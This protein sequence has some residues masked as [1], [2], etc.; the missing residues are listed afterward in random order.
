[1]TYPAGAQ[2]ST[3]LTTYTESS[4][5]TSS[6]TYT[7]GTTQFISTITPT[8]YDGALLLSGWRRSGCSATFPF[9]AKPGDEITINF[10]SDTPIDFHLVWSIFPGVDGTLYC[11]LGG[12]AS[13]LSDADY[14]TSYS[15]KWSPPIDHYKVTGNTQFYIVLA[16]RQ[17][18]P[19]SV[20]LTARETLSQMASSTIYATTT[21]SMT[22]FATR[23]LSTITT[24]KPAESPPLTITETTWIILLAI[25]LGLA[26][27]F[28]SIKRKKPPPE[29]TQ[30]Y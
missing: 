8:I 24:L 6:N 2:V 9:N 5:L 14:Q 21:T 23:T 13:S 25:L 11:G 28:Y 26:A 16:N 7:I 4:T 3:S 1:M 12:Y 27:V 10:K 17:A 29:K 22:L 19:A 15:L 18:T 20:S 30:I